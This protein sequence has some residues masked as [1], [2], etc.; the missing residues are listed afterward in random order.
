M[1]VFPL[2]LANDHDIHKKYEKIA[3]HITMYEKIAK[4]ITV[5]NLI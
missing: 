2:G 5:S 4:H 1:R 3:K